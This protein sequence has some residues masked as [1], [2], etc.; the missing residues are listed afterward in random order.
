MI[1][2]GFPLSTR[3]LKGGFDEVKKSQ[4]EEKMKKI[5]L[6]A[7]LVAFVAFVPSVASAEPVAPIAASQ[8]VVAA[9]PAQGPLWCMPWDPCAQ[10]PPVQ[11]PPPQPPAP[12]PP[13]QAD[14]VG[15]AV[16]QSNTAKVGSW[17]GTPLYWDGGTWKDVNGVIFPNGNETVVTTMIKEGESATLLGVKVTMDYSAGMMFIRVDGGEKVVSAPPVTQS[18]WITSMETWRKNMGTYNFYV[19]KIDLVPSRGSTSAKVGYFFVPIA[20]AAPSAAPAKPPCEF[21]GILPPSVLYVGV[22]ASQDHFLAITDT[23]DQWVEAAQV[24]QNWN[25]TKAYLK[26]WTR[27]YKS[28]CW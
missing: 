21:V 11:P 18:G 9:P 10:Q 24:T 23:K 14:A 1:L 7:L 20:G 8:V 3:W 16:Y 26:G 13:L 12:I 19:Y 4:G 2:M 15:T 17:Q 25:G 28:P 22:T 6:F 27:V 5:V